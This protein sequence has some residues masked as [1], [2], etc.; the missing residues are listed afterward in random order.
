MASASTPAVAALVRA[1]IAH[2]LHPY[3]H[4]PRSTAFGDEVVQ[5]LALDARRV[6]KTLVAQVDGSLTVGIVPVAAHLNLKALASA[7]G[8]KKGAMAPVAEAERSS[9]YVAGGISPLGQRKAL[10]TVIDASALGFETV[11]V[12]AGKRGLQVELRPADLITLTS[13][14]SA[15]IAAFD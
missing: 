6:F 15:A 3:Q 13:A 1:K 10:T 5:A 7:V 8:G 11:F 9:G 2:T 4:D 12:S 14:R